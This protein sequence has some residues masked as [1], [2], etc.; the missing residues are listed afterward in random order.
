M[1]KNILPILIFTACTAEAQLALELTF[2][3]SVQVYGPVPLRPG[4]VPG[5]QTLQ[6]TLLIPLIPAV[7]EKQ[8]W[9][10]PALIGS[11]E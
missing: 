3:N 10:Y 1:I 6:A 8:C 9:K 2:A 7:G 11:D 4:V 5:N